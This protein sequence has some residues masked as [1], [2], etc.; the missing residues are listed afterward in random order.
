ML[1]SKLDSAG[2]DVTLEFQDV[3]LDVDFYRIDARDFLEILDRLEGPCLVRYSI[4]AAACD[5]RS[6]RRLSSSIAVALFK[7]TWG[8]VAAT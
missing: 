3:F 8:K 6:E 2:S 7:L 1:H 4:T 5:L